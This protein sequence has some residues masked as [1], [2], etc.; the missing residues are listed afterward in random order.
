MED[1]IG[2]LDYFE[3]LYNIKNKFEREPTFKMTY[4]DAFLKLTEQEKES[5]QQSFE[6]LKELNMQGD[7]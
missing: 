2:D 6:S 4:Q 5:L 1:F 7:F 3:D